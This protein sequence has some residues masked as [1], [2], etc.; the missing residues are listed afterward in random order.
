M[1]SAYTKEQHLEMNRTAWD[2]AHRIA[3]VKMRNNPNWGEEFQD[4]GVPFDD[5]ELALLGSIQGLDVLQL[6]CAGDASQAF[7]L[8]NMGAKVTACDFSS[9]AIKTAK[10]N[11]DRIGLA[12]R[13]VVDDSQLLST[14]KASQFD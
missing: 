10:E 6:S 11:A 7:S 3:A 1:S 8:A 5:T 2:D 12:V 13:F 4:G 14:L 9:V